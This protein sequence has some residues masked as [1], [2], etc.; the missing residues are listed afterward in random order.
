MCRCGSF[1]IVMMFTTTISA[2][3]VYRTSI[4]VIAPIVW[5]HI[6]VVVV[7]ILFSIIV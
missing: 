6:T 2:T 5:L 1:E 7:M 3:S 4:G